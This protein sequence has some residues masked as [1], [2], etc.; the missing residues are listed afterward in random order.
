MEQIRE[1]IGKFEIVITKYPAFRAYKLLTKLVASLGPALAMLDTD[2]PENSKAIMG[3]LSRLNEGDLSRLTVEVLK[4]TSVNNG[5]QIVN[6]DSEKSIDSAFG[7]DLKAM[8]DTVVAVL[9]ANY[10]SFFEE[11]KTEYQG[12][13]VQAEKA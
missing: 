7:S 9:K 5:N 10:A 3:A 8:L 6:I 11:A 13:L 2:N 4:G 1:Q 12:A